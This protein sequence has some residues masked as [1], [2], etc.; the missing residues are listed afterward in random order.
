[1]GVDAVDRVDRVDKVDARKPGIV[2]CDGTGA[3]IPKGELISER[4][5]RLMMPP[6]HPV[7]FVH[8]VHQP[9]TS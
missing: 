7:H 1:M 4:G 2:T 9:E 5:F 6:G 8:Y 3:K